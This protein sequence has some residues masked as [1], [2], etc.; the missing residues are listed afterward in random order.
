MADARREALADPFE[1]GEL[2]LLLLLRAREEVVDG[3]DVRDEG[4]LR[5]RRVVGEDLRLQGQHLLGRVR[6]HHRARDVHLPGEDFVG[7]VRPLAG[8]AV[9]G[10]ARAELVEVVLPGIVEK[11]GDLPHRHDGEHGGD[12]DEPP[13]VAGGQVADDP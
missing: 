8:S 5:I 6:E 9:V 4:A 7:L 1:D 12:A 3:R 10:A 13:R 2:L 11:G